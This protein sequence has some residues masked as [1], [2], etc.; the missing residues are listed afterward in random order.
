[1]DMLT[2]ITENQAFG[3]LPTGYDV[4][5]RKIRDEF[6]QSNE[7]VFAVAYSCNYSEEESES[8]RGK[9]IPSNSIYRSAGIVTITTFRWLWAGFRSRNR[10]GFYSHVGSGNSGGITYKKSGSSFFNLSSLPYSEWHWM[11]P[12]EKLSKDL[13]GWVQETSLLELANVKNREKFSVAHK[14]QRIDLLEISL[15]N[16]TQFT[17]LLEEGNRIYELLQIARQN[18]GKLAIRRAASSPLAIK[19]TG[20]TENL[21]KLAALFQ[22]GIL[23]REEFETIK[24][25]TLK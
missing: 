5:Y 25:R 16:N 15:T 18:K 24:K 20:V 2:A 19:D 17:F 12:T 8:S 1:M 9:F 13:E 4:L 14:G 3:N 7:D 22:S 21:E 11:P 6:L 23:T 10:D